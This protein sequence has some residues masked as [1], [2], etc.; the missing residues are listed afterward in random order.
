MTARRECQDATRASPSPGRTAP[1]I[2]STIYWEWHDGSTWKDFAQDASDTIEAIY[3]TGGTTVSL[4]FGASSYTL[5]LTSLK[6]TNDKT[7]FQRNIRR[8]AN[9]PRG[10]SNTPILK[11]AAST[12]STRTI[13]KTSTPPAPPGKAGGS[14]APTAGYV[15]PALISTPSSIM[16][17]IDKKSG[18]GKHPI[19]TPPLATATRKSSGKPKSKYTL[20]SESSSSDFD[21]GN[22]GSISSG[23]CSGSDSGTVQPPKKKIFL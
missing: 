5:D 4:T 18:S 6:Q 8:K 11:K 20:D 7:N 22:S 19:P 16:S 3:Q 1:T 2:M 13:S 15:A 14:N 9:A 12:G 17:A 10:T 23:S 21:L